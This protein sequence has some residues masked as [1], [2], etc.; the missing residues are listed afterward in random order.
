MFL[1]Y[2][3]IIHHFISLTERI[4]RF[5]W[6]GPY[7]ATTWTHSGRFVWIFV[8]TW[9]LFS[10]IV[11]LRPKINNFA[12][13]ESKQDSWGDSWRAGRVERKK[14][15][16]QLLSP[17]SKTSKKCPDL[18]KRGSLKQSKD[19]V[20]GSLAHQSFYLFSTRNVS[21]Q[22]CFHFCISVRDF[23]L[24]HFNQKVPLSN[25]FVFLSKSWID[26]K[27]SWS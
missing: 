19:D 16:G 5:C 8:N 22:S 26:A 9:C 20:P 11:M 17:S 1:Y 3:F 15:R 10:C 21:Q 24:S 7:Q 18:G 14:K 13:Q 4:L 27:L 2:F 25:L 6:N 12:P 23:Y